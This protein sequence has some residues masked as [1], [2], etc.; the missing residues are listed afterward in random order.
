MSFRCDH[1]GNCTQL[2]A[3]PRVAGTRRPALFALATTQRQFH[4]QCNE[5]FV[6]RVS[7]CPLVLNSTLDSC[8]PA[9]LCPKYM[10]ESAVI[11]AGARARATRG[12]VLANTPRI[13][14]EFARGNFL[15]F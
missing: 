3:C 14:R 4:I 1:G 2:R 9:V 11:L 7:L 10:V 6:E 12:N 8:R 13:C 5:I 15:Q